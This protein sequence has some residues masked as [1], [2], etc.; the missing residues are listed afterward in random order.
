[1]DVVLKKMKLISTA[2]DNYQLYSS[3]QTLSYVNRSKPNSS[4]TVLSRIDSQETILDQD[5]LQIRRTDEVQ[6]EYDL[7]AQ[8]KPITKPIFA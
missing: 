7:Q 4:S 2:N 5:Q 8:T 1:M 6:I 3:K